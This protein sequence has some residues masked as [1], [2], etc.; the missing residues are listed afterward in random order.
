MRGGAGKEGRG[1]QGRRGWGGETVN[2]MVS[3]EFNAVE[4]SSNLSSQLFFRL[5][6]EDRGDF[7][8]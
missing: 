7:H 6:G 1:G 3:C 2:P 8:E 4:D 5:R